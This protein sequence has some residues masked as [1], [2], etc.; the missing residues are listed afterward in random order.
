MFSRAHLLIEKEYKKL[1]DDQPWVTLKSLNILCFNDL[2]LFTCFNNVKY[3]KFSKNTVSVLVLIDGEIFYE[4]YNYIESC[5]LISVC[6]YFLGYR[7]HSP[8]RGQYF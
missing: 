1:L 6:I 8:S 2:K 7:S 3:L 4:Y 5:L